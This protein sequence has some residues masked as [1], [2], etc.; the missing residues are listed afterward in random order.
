ML[1]VIDPDGKIVVLAY[2]ITSKPSAGRH[3]DLDRA[4][5]P[6]VRCSMVN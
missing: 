1:Y 2:D 3:G 5:P 4:R 6:D